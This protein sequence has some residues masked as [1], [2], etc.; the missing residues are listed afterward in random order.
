MKTTLYSLLA[1]AAALG[2]A[3]AQTAYTTPV[4]YITTD[5]YGNTSNTGAGASTFVTA[6]MLNPAVF[7]G[8]TTGAPSGDTASFSGS[9]PTDLDGSYVLE[10]SEGVSEGWWTTVVSSTANSIKVLDSF[11]GG[12]PT[13]TKITVRKFTTISNVFGDNE[14]GLLPFSEGAYDEIQML[15]PETQQI[16]VIVYADGWFDL[17]TESAAEN[18]IIYPGTSVRVVRRGTSPLSLVTTGEVKTTKTQVDLFSSDNWFG[19]PN[20]TG[21][22]FGEMSFGSQILESD[23]IIVVG[24][25]AGSGQSAVAY[26]SFEGEM[27]DLGSEAPADNLQLDGGTGFILRRPVGGASIIELPAQVIGN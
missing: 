9:V 1:A 22:T 17:G 25:D 13:N 21:N 2:F 27:F 7:A 24:S 3:Q 11:P 14:A 8:A 18:F 26:V 15:S 20:A 16:S 23:T 19:L 5:I 4:G 10:I 6:T 12:L